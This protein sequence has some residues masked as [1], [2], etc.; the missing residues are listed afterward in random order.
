M[1]TPASS[2]PAGASPDAAAGPNG[3]A[4]DRALVRAWCVGFVLVNLA[5]ALG[6]PALD[7]R[8]PKGPLPH[9]PRVLGR[10][11]TRDFPGL[12]RSHALALP[13][14]PG[15][16][17]VV[18]TGNCMAADPEA[19]RILS[20]TVRAVRP[21]AALY[22]IA[23]EALTVPGQAQFVARSLE[24]G[25]DVA[26]WPI[27]LRDCRTT[28]GLFTP[29][30]P[31]LSV[32]YGEGLLPALANL[33]YLN[34]ENGR[35]VVFNLIAQAVP[36]ERYLGTLQLSRPELPEPPPVPEAP[37]ATPRGPAI[38][39]CPPAEYPP[40]VATD[41]LAEVLPLLEAG[42]CRLVVVIPPHAYRE[43]TYG[44]GAFERFETL[45]GEWCA[46]HGVPLIDL[47][48][49]VPESAFSD[50]VHY[51]HGCTGLVSQRLAEELAPVLRGE[52]P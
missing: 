49:L 40:T 6:G 22:G 41:A 37:A 4:R 35:G 44:P 12:F 28:T 15:E 16:I 36:A 38:R 20:D 14:A 3:P 26:V 31:A 18:V 9:H 27:A 19:M 21:E 51:D 42:R 30:V 2:L 8:L 24:Y 45:V 11:Y 43:Q 52:D 1:S 10:I 23:W 34:W 47:S 25:P 50:D 17:R 39:P 5:L 32:R 48:D 7:A 29:T 46:R 13:K 33:R